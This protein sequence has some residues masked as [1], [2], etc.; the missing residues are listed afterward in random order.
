[1]NRTVTATGMK[2]QATSSQSLVIANTIGSTGV[3]TE[4]TVTFTTATRTLIPATYDAS[5]EYTTHLKYVTNPGSVSAGTGLQAGSTAL[6]YADA[7]NDETESKYYYIDYVVY[8]A[9]SGG[10]LTNQKLNAVLTQT[11]SLDTDTI[12]ATSVDFY[13]N[14][15]STSLGTYAGTLNIAGLNRSTNDGTTALTSVDLLS[16]TGATRVIPEN[17]STSTYLQITM[18]VYFDGALLKTA[19]PA[20]AY[21]YSD[22]VD[23]TEVGFKVDFTAQENT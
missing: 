3:G 11:T 23:T 14:R 21:V 16:Y 13:V 10:E 9:S 18:R 19:S 5:A 20:Q 15:N 8:I 1:M 6:V 22:N 4:T 12:K 7:I 2:V 17:K